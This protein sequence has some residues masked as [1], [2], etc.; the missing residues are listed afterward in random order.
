MAWAKPPVSLVQLFDQ[1]VPS[2]PPAQ[3]REMFGQPCVFANGNMFAGLFAD[4]MMLRLPDG[5]RSRFLRMEGGR[6]F[7]P[8]PGRVMR[9]YV[10]VPRHLLADRSTLTNW[11]QSALAY[12]ASLPPKA[13][14]KAKKVKKKVK[15]EVGKKTKRKTKK[16]TK[17]RKV[18][19]KTKKRKVK[20]KTKKRKTKK[21]TKKRKTK[22][23]TKKRKVKKKTKRKVKKK[24]KR[25]AK[26]GRR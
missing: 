9:E 11:L 6:P 14:K 4:R 22:K 10:E 25:K 3:R 2:A 13:E 20:K 21:K 15:K 19:R 7:E 26:T 17:K 16:K 5:L 8:T 12:A 18:K 1:V 24:T 23:K